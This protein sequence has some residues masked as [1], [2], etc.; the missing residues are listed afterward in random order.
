M[1]KVSVLIALFWLTQLPAYPADF[2][3]KLGAGLGH[4]NFPNL[5]R[6]LNDWEKRQVLEAQTRNTWSYIS[7]ETGALHSS[8]DLEGELILNFH[9]NGAVSFSSGVVYTDISAEKTNLVI[10]R[11][12]GPFDNIHPFK[13]SGFPFIV[14]AYF[15]LPL[16]PETQ[17]FL[18][19]GAGIMTARLVEQSGFKKAEN[20][21]YVLELEQNS[22]GTGPVYLGSTGAFYQITTGTTIFIEGAYRNSR[23]KNFTASGQENDAVLYIYN[24]Y[25]SDLDTWSKVL[26][27]HDNKPEGDDIASVEKASVDLSGFSLKLGVMIRF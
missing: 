27:L 18:R 24:K 13:V 17:L 19:A 6:V 23:I 12:L 4:M 21:K 9:R 10:E 26:R 7:G 15:K 11:N 5:N 2:Y 1:K 22:L 20:T 16:N 8:F 25:Y 14:S 3:L